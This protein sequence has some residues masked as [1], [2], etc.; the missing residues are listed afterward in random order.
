MPEFSAIS[1]AAAA[2]RGWQPR[3]EA[4]YR[5]VLLAAGTALT[6]W[7]AGLWV[8]VGGAFG[9]CWAGMVEAAA[10]QLAAVALAL[11]LS[12]G[13]LKLVLLLSR[14]AR[15]GEAP[16]WQVLLADR[17]KASS[18]RRAKQLR[19]LLAVAVAACAAGGL[20]STVGA[21]LAPFALRR[22]AGMFLYPP[23]M[24]S[25]ARLG[26]Q[27]LVFLPMAAA[28]AGLGLLGPL[29][30]RYGASDPYRYL[31][32]DLT[33]SSSAGLAA[34]AGLWWAGA[35]LQGIAF[36]CA[37]ALV[38]LSAA[39]AFKKQL[40]A[41]A[42]RLAGPDTAGGRWKRQ[43]WLNLGASALLAWILA[44]Q[45]RALRDGARCDWAATWI[46]VAAT[47]GVAAAVTGRLNRR[48]RPASAAEGRAAAA[49]P[50]VVAATQLGLLGFAATR[51]WGWW[52]WIGLAAAAQVPFAALAATLLARRRRLSGQAGCPGRFWLADGAL[53]AA[54]G[55]AGATFMLA[56]PKGL[57]VAAVA[58]MVGLTVVFL[59]GTGAM[60]RVATR[61]R[62]PGPLGRQL[63]WAAAG[64]AAILAV[65][66][67]W[68][69]LRQA[70][71]AG[72][73]RHVFVGASLTAYQ[74]DAGAVAALPVQEARQGSVLLTELAR[75]LIQSREG[76]WWVISA[77]EPG[78][79]TGLGEGVRASRYFPGEAFRYLLAW[80]R[81]G[82]PKSFARYLNIHIHDLDGVYLDGL[83]VDHPDA[84]CLYNVEA[85]L[86]ARSRIAP[87]GLMILRVA[88]SEGRLA[89]LLRVVKTFDWVVA[90][91]TAAVVLEG[92]RAEVLLAARWRGHNPSAGLE[93]LR[94]GGEGVEVISV[95]DLLAI[96]P[97]LRPMT[98]LAPGRRTPAEVDISALAYWLRLRGK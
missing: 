76:S 72:P 35:D 31:T 34:A 33:W 91:G 94:P 81:A 64:A 5:R 28:I 6:V 23:W 66:S 63:R 53:G 59:A 39:T 47:A 52:I 83:S 21:Q 19:R 44:M 58:M 3:A 10:C 45:C 18:A 92:G 89:D 73:R 8:I 90:G 2:G 9:C 68:V 22:L 41:K 80:G 48:V 98:V 30:R 56:W 38:G 51:P 24:W 57:L 36:V 50:V 60:A 79:L 55:A 77:R 25:A 42:V 40:A 78:L 65:A 7:S 86:G 17:G 37:A 29:L 85:L 12:N 62:G 20:L 46:W 43:R 15:A 4:F 96:E 13:V 95:K 11:G 75:Q 27:V 54:A 88:G 26:L 16:A 71:Q 87:G 93:A 1:G 69:G 70:W 84:W 49:G 32:T 97:D 67:M 14:R 82:R 74:T 61:P